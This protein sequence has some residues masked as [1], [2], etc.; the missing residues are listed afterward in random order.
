ME[1]PDWDEEPNW[2]EPNWDEQPDWCDLKYL[3]LTALYIF[4]KVPEERLRFWLNFYSYLTL[5][6]AGAWLNVPRI[7]QLANLL[8]LPAEVDPVCI[9]I[10]PESKSLRNLGCLFSQLVIDWHNNQPTSCIM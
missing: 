7:C 1:E 4:T 10:D 9:L 2:D 5:S 8:T 3:S 6:R